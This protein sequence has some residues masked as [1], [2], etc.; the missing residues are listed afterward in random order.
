MLP[1]LHV[2]DE[3]EYGEGSDQAVRFATVLIS[4]FTCITGILESQET[5]RPTPPVVIY[6]IDPAYTQEAL[7]AKL[8]GTVLLRA[9][10]ET[11]GIASGIKV[12]RKLG[13]GLD[14][15]AVECVQAWRFQPAMLHGEAIPMDVGVEL[16]FH[17]PETK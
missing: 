1:S 16:N 4:A 15:K 5:S 14:E 6:Q 13:R 8:E 17:L 10:V 7:D 9:T 11:D 3:M 12:L 2:A